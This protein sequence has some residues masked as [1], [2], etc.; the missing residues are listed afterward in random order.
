M[1]GGKEFTGLDKNLGLKIGVLFH[2]DDLRIHKK[3]GTIQVTTGTS[4]EN[5]FKRK[6]GIIQVVL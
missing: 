1:N 3:L 6:I 2:P 5:R 4:T